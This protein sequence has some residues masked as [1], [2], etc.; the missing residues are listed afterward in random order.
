MRGSEEEANRPHMTRPSRF[1]M[2]PT[3]AD[4][5]FLPSYAVAGRPMEVQM[6][7]KRRKK[8]ANR[9]VFEE[10]HYPP[11]LCGRDLALVGALTGPEAL[12]FR[13]SMIRHSKFQIRLYS[14]LP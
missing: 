8:R 1:G 4:L 3:P 5:S 6:T 14:I 11:N 7:R 12:A 10:G 9:S 13:M 2:S